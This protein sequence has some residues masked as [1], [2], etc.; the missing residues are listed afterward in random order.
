MSVESPDWSREDPEFVPGPARDV[1]EPTRDR[2]ARAAGQIALHPRSS[3]LKPFALRILS[4]AEHG[5]D[6]ASAG[7]R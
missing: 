1:P 4:A 7:S 6:R 2:V 5:S 3:R